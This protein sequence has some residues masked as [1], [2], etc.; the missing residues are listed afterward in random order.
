MNR[1]PLIIVAFLMA[2]AARAAAPAVIV[3]EDFEKVAVGAI[4]AGFTKTGAIAVA[5]GVAHSGT[6]ALKVEPALRGGR[7]VT[8]PTDVVDKLGGEQWGRLYYK[9][10][11]PAPSPAPQE[12]KKGPPAIHTTLVAAKA[13]SPL[14][15]DSIEVRLAGLSLNSAGEFRYL[16]NV[17]PKGGRKEFGTRAE[18]T[19]KFTDEW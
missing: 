8:L 10:Q 17:Q 19:H 11:L 13:T 14:A 2:G 6:H 9:V 1:V 7:F 15:H 5:E 4:P 18:A 3:T 16:Y 12:G